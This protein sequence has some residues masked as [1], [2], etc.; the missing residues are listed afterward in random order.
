M[1]C[2]ACSARILDVAVLSMKLTS[3]GTDAIVRPRRAALRIISV[4]ISNPSDSSRTSDKKRFDMRR[5]PD[6]VS[7]RSRPATTPTQKF[8]Q[9]FPK[10][11]RKRVRARPVARRPESAPL[12][13][14]VTTS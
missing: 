4:S 8:V 1:T 7:G 5:N 2:A 11:R 6:C 3:M 13:S 10:R 12:T 14:I 9:R